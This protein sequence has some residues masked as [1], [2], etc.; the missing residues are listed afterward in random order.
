MP[1]FFPLYGFL[2]RVIGKEKQG[3]EI[4]FY[5]LFLTFYSSI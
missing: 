2:Y 5:T 3:A 1:L 4:I